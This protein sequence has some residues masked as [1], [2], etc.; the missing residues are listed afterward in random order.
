M[1]H[2]VTVA[3][4]CVGLD[5]L[6]LR[7]DDFQS[8]TPPLIEHR[9]RPRSGGSRLLA[10]PDLRKSLDVREPTDIC[11]ALWARQGCKHRPV[12]L[13]GVSAN[14][15]NEEPL[16]HLSNSRGHSG[17]PQQVLGFWVTAA[18]AASRGV[19]HGPGGATLSPS[20]YAR[21]LDINPSKRAGSSSHWQRHLI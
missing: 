21:D 7:R 6:R 8:A 15:S 19:R 10:S 5:R 11:S 9:Y 17:V 13:G 2:A 12:S 20:A 16:V 14:G 1:E 18:I 3:S 4:G